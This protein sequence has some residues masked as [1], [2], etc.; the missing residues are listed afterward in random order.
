MEKYRPLGI[1][2]LGR[3]IKNYIKIMTETKEIV[4]LKG[5]VSKLVEQASEIT[6]ATAEDNAHATEIKAKLNETKKVI[7]AR[8]EEI[9]KPLNAALKSARDLFAPIE[10]QYE[11]AES[12]LATKL[13]GYKRKVEAETEA[14][15]AKLAARVEKGTMKI[16]TAERKIGELPTVQTTVQTEHGRVQFRKVKKMRVV[17]ESK[18]P[19]EY[20]VVD[21]VAL[22]RD[23]L[24]TGFMGLVFGGACEVYEEEIV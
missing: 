12:I 1:I 11:E 22:C 3:Y 9:T 13:I 17:D 8:K 23:A 20:W 7:K 24:A 6:I 2:Y 15:A 18:V 4:A 21:M 5:Q 16:E 14:A 19:D 10:S